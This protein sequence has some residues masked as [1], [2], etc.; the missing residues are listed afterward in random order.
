MNSRAKAAMVDV[1]GS[2]QLIDVIIN[3]GIRRIY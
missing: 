1:P 2:K 3:L